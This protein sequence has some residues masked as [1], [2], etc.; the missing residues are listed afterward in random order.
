[1]A[2]GKA[3]ASPSSPAPLGHSLEVCWFPRLYLMSPAGEVSCL[4][5]KGEDSF[6]GPVTA[7]GQQARTTPATQQRGRGVLAWLLRA[8]C[9]FCCPPEATVQGEEHRE[10]QWPRPSLGHHL[11]KLGTVAQTQSRLWQGQGPSQLGSQVWSSSLSPA[12]R[13]TSSRG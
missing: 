1:M 3:S 8:S 13:G 2:P 9:P 5:T 4:P 10:A 6:R 11:P 7:R 12:V